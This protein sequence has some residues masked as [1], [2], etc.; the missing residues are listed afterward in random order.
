MTEEGEYSLKIGKEIKQWLFESIKTHVYLFFST[1]FSTILQ[2][3]DTNIENL[4]VIC[5]I[6]IQ[7]DL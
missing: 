2:M 3:P 5:L 6:L 4:N 1:G 7:T